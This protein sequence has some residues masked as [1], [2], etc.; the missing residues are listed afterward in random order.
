LD[1]T[2][3]LPNIILEAGDYYVICGNSLNVKN[4]D[5]DV[6]PDS[7]VIQNGSPD[8]IALFLGGQPG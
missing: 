8:A 7:N 3:P 4:C 6:S 2:I 1:K 5:L